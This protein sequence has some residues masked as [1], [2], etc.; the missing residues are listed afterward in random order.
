MM[1]SPETYYEEYL[2][3]KTPSQIM[4]AIVSSAIRL[5]IVLRGTDHRSDSSFTVN[6]FFASFVFPFSSLFWLLAIRT[7][8]LISISLYT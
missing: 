6:V 7:I 4:T 5:Y 1:I 3:G 2:K 8:S